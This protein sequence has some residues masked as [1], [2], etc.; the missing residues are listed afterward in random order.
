MEVSLLFLVKSLVF[1]YLPFSFIGSIFIL[2]YYKCLQDFIYIYIFILYMWTYQCSLSLSLSIYIYIYIILI[3]TDISV[4]S[5]KPTEADGIKRNHHS[6]FIFLFFSVC[7]STICEH[8]NLFIYSFIYSVTYLMSI[9]GVLRARFTGD[10]I[11]KT[12]K[13]LPTW[14]LMF[15]EKRN[16]REIFV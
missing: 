4:F 14:L 3:C 7:F 9:E 10:I 5:F 13:F 6:L 12:T 8:P 15:W 2:L 1:A 16:S 11:V